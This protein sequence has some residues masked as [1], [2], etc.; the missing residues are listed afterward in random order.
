MLILVQKEHE[1]DQAH[2]FQGKYFENFE[3]Y[4]LRIMY[5]FENINHNNSL[6]L[7]VLK[8]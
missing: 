4:Q 3:I 1:Q 8:R 2:V 5:H 6:I 7:F